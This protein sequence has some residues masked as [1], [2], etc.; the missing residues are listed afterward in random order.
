MSGNR[1]PALRGFI[2]CIGDIKLV[3]GGSGVRVSA[4]SLAGP[5]YLV[6]RGTDIP[7]GITAGPNHPAGNSMVGAPDHDF[8]APIAHLD[9]N[10]THPFS[11]MPTR[12]VLKVQFALFSSAGAGFAVGLPDRWFFAVSSKPATLSWIKN[13]NW[14][15]EAGGNPVRY[16]QDRSAKR[17]WLQPL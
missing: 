13:K 14:A 7:S 10:Y 1:E 3:I 6:S 16:A 12:I 11:K 2:V 5:I 15:I 9:G 8:H 17:Q 4:F